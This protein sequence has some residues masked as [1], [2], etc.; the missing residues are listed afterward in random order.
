[1]EI[2]NN[3]VIEEKE[4]IHFPKTST[5]ILAQL[6]D[7][8]ITLLVSIILS[9]MAVQ[10][11][12][13]F[14][15]YYQSAVNYQGELL[16]IAI[17]SHLIQYKGVTYDSTSAA[18]YTSATALT[19]DESYVLFRDAYLDPAKVINDKGTYNDNILYY[20]VTYSENTIAWLNQNILKLPATIDGANTNVFFEYDSGSADPL[21]SLSTLKASKKVLLAQ[22]VS[23]EVNDAS[24]TA[25]NDFIAYYKTLL[26]N[27]QEDLSKSEPYASILPLYQEAYS[28]TAWTSTIS[29]FI[30]FGV[31]FLVFYLLIPL[32]SKEKKTIGKRVMKL[33]TINEDGS[34]IKW[35][36]IL[37]RALIL[38]VTLSFGVVITPFFTWS[39]YSLSL[40][41]ISFGDFS[42]TLGT[43]YIFSGIFIVGTYVCMIAT[44]KHQ[45]LHDLICKTVVID[46]SYEVFKPAKK[47]DDRV[48]DE[49]K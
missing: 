49:I 5:R 32:L 42:L 23:G 15:G 26:T 20:Y 35:H 27:A 3:N 4:E 1:M 30:T 36:Q 14:I 34:K 41:F 17:D 9:T 28:K 38:M 29:A 25:N 43:L 11:M 6:A 24:S 10:P 13:G 12:L 22:F 48:V 39:F 47:I 45:A 31:V 40:P 18:D 44:K 2:T 16:D 33:A 46:T 7:F 21:N 8:A 37:F 19:L